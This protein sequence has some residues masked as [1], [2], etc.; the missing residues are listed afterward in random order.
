MAGAPV[1]PRIEWVM[2]QH[3]H[4]VH[5]MIPSRIAEE[6][7]IPV[8]DVDIAIAAYEDDRRRPYMHDIRPEVPKEVQ[9]PTRPVFPD[10]APADVAEGPP[11]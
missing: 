6:L 7:G 9:R 11:E 1:G 4:G 3:L 2:I 10:P 5:R 8:E